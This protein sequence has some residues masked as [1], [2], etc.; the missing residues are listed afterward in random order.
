MKLEKYNLKNQQQK[1]RCS[2]CCIA[3]QFSNIPTVYNS[4]VALMQSSLSSKP[5]SNHRLNIVFFFFCPTFQP[6]SS[7]YWIAYYK[8]T[9]QIKTRGAEEK[10]R[11]ECSKKE[12]WPVKQKHLI[13][14]LLA[15]LGHCFSSFERTEVSVE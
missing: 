9:Q 2:G 10:E 6:N 15:I 14:L 13:P 7:K 8:F 1:G 3:A 12:F 4:I 5:F 11:K